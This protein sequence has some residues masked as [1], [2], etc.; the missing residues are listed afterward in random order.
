MKPA[1]R[2]FAIL[3]GATLLLA[4]IAITAPGVQA[5]PSADDLL[6][7][8]VEQDCPAETT[9]VLAPF[10]PPEQDTCTHCHV[11][12]SIENMAAPLTRWVLFGLFGAVF[13]FGAFRTASIWKTRAPWKPLIARAVDWFDER[14]KV[15]EPL[16]K[17][18]DK[19]VPTFATYWWYCLG[20][21]TFLLFLVQGVTGTLLAFYYQPT[22]EMAYKSIQFIENE[23]RFGSSIRM[24]HHW[25][26]NGMVL[27][28]VAHMLRVFITGAYKAPREL[29]WISGLMLGLL[30]LGF[31]FTGYLLPWDQRAYWAT[32]VGTEI[33]GG[34]PQIGD[35]VLVFLRGGWDVGAVTLSRFFAA[36]VLVLPALIIIFMLMHFLMIR[37]TGVARPL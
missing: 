27:M 29:N 11:S 37:K 14:Y 3:I 24:I 9:T 35:I 30:T 13:A 7:G 2:I 12:G 26:A 23:V 21:I 28:A 6:P 15:K 33:G 1:K 20:G 31:G 18:L 16:Q 22:P 10:P 19:P 8:T 4:L 25:S 17:V 5:G 34:V 32:T 36:H